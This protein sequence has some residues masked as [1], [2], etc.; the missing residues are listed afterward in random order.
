MSSRWDDSG[1]GFSKAQLNRVEDFRAW[2]RTSKMKIG[3]ELA[4]PPAEFTVTRTTASGRR[5]MRRLEKTLI[6]ERSSTSAAHID[7]QILL[8]FVAY[9]NRFGAKLP[10]PR[11]S[12]LFTYP[13][14]PFTDDVALARQH[15]QEW[16]RV[17]L[18]WIEESG[19]KPSL[20]LI[21]FS[22]ILHGGLLHKNCISAFTR[23]LLEPAGKIGYAGRQTTVALD[24]AW[25]GLPSM[26]F[27]SWQPDI[28]TACAVVPPN[29]MSCT[30]SPNS[31]DEQLCRAIYKQIVARLK[32]LGT[33]EKLLP[34]SLKKM[35]D[36]VALGAR[37]EVPAVLVDYATRQIVS[38]SLRPD[39]LRRIYAQPNLTDGPTSLQ[40]P[41]P[42]GGDDRSQEPTI[43]LS[44]SECEN[45][46]D[47][48]PTGLKWLRTALKASSAEVALPGL[49]RLLHEYDEPER[50]KTVWHL[51]TEFAEYL[52]SRR[53]V[54]R[55]GAYSKHNL[56]LSTVRAYAVN[57]VGRRFGRLLEGKG[58]LD[59]NAI[60]FEDYYTQ[61]IENSLG[62]EATNRQKRALIGALREFHDFL[63]QEHEAAPIRDSDVFGSVRGLLPVDATIITLEEYN[64]ARRLIR[65]DI[66]NV[67]D[68]RARRIAEAMLIIGFKCG[69][70]RMEVLNLSIADLLIKGEPWLFI[71]PWGDHT[72]KTI[73]ATRQI[74]LQSLLDEDELEVL[75]DCLNDAQAFSNVNKSNANK[76]N[77]NKY[78][79]G[80]SDNCSGFRVIPQ[81]M[82]M[83]IVHR[84]LRESTNDSRIR[85]HHCRH[86]FATWT[87]LRL[88]L[89]DLEAI[90]DLFPHLPETRVWLQ[91][92]RAFRRSF[93]RGNGNQT[94]RHVRAVA[95]LLGHS[96]PLV[97]LE[98]YIH[99]LD[100]LLPHFLESSTLLGNA[101][102]KD[103]ATLAR[104]AESSVYGAVVDHNDWLQN[105]TPLYE[106]RSKKRKAD[107]GKRLHRL[108]TAVES[109]LEK[110]RTARDRHKHA[111]EIL[112]NRLKKL[113]A[114]RDKRLNPPLSLP[115]R[116]FRERF[117]E[118]APL[119]ETSFDQS[120]KQDVSSAPSILDHW[121]VLFLR[122]TTKESLDSIADHFGLNPDE[123]NQ[124]IGRV[125]DL[126][127]I[128][129]P[130]GT[131]VKRHKSIFQLGQV[132]AEGSKLDL[133]Y[134]KLPHSKQSRQFIKELEGRL[135]ICAQKYSSLTRSV[136]TYYVNNIWSSENVL[137]F[138]DPADPQSAVA[139]LSFLKEL[140]FG[141]PGNAP[142][143]FISFDKA[144]ISK[145]R[146]GWQAALKLTNREWASVE[147]R[148]PLY[149]PCRANR[150][151]LSIGPRLNSDE[152]EAY[153]FLMIMA[154][155]VFGF[156]EPAKDQT[157][158]GSGV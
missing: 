64:E 138:R 45:P 16:K 118:I 120:A 144:Q 148:N 84:A 110:L 87:L 79:F 67:P 88:M 105:A 15:I 100:W 24:L 111:T 22:A 21:A 66:Q 101:R 39:V 151:W 59:L 62:D 142:I 126:H 8:K 11:I 134:P 89:S 81:D 125:H 97:S 106:K 13:S 35:L 25:N 56:A 18:N 71:R 26:E 123:A 132:D 86:S 3:R 68:L 46:D 6:L 140:E 96:G 37:A 30:L 147:L 5:E 157:E 7:S 31:S 114:D 135:M 60:E 74:P 47:Q 136:L 109:R 40:S 80:I 124:M 127:S 27:R 14:N 119:Y 112:A 95:S 42:K 91:K 65:S 50:R 9:Q 128:E 94:R 72:L 149:A 57:L 90:P 158:A 139:Y 146:N 32:S 38:H 115:V 155:I 130:R 43:R 19:S 145:A 69:A 34:Q 133:F 49:R 113:R 23:A 48:E 154:A 129:E 29:Q 33:S 122:Q 99:C 63:V 137:A 12:T 107:R 20:A 28:S 70:R 103:I 153:R 54:I 41:T 78:L 93:Y 116:V 117:P 1:I 10:V 52:L 83:P 55:P 121:S 85:F 17:E 98:H 152:D 104:C 82:I 108:I 53:Q 51:I 131:K 150:K 143:R 77:V 36:T 58:P 141:N 73:N 76:S 61:A 4:D 44:P 75:R 156:S 92:S 2:L 102:A